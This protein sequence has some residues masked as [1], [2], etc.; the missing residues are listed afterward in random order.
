MLFRSFS[1]NIF[2]SNLANTAVV[3]STITEP[4][5]KLLATPAVSGFI[6]KIDTGIKTI[7]G[8]IKD[9]SVF[10]AD[11]TPIGTVYNAGKETL[12]TIW[13][14]TPDSVK[15]GIRQTGVAGQALGSII[16]GTGKELVSESQSIKEKGIATDNKVL[17]FLGAAGGM[18]VGAPFAVADIGKGV[19]TGNV[20]GTASKLVS[21]TEGMLYE[22]IKNPAVG[23]GYIAGGYV[24]GKAGEAIIAP[25]K[26]LFVAEDI[27][28]GTK[29]AKV[30][31]A[32]GKIETGRGMVE[33]FVVKDLIKD[34]PEIRFM[35]TVSKTTTPIEV[36]KLGGTTTVG[37][38]ASP[39]GSSP[40]SFFKREFTVAEQSGTG[41]TRTF[42]GDSGWFTAPAELGKTVPFSVKAVSEA[43]K[44]DL[45]TKE[46]PTLPG[47]TETQGKVLSS[48]NKEVLGGSFAG[49]TLFK[50]FR[51]HKDLDLISINPLATAT[52]IAKEN[53]NVFKINRGT[54]GKYALV[55]K[56]TGKGVADI[57]TPDLYKKGI[58]GGAKSVSVDGFNVLSP[59][60]FLNI[61]IKTIER[62]GETSRVKA[63]KDIASISE[64][65]LK[66]GELLKPS[67]KAGTPIVY[68]DYF[69]LNSKVSFSD[70]LSGKAKLG[71]G[72]PTLHIE[73]AQK[74]TP[75]P[76]WMK[77]PATAAEK[78]IVTLE[79]KRLAE[80]K[81]TAKIKLGESGEVLTPAQLQPLANKLLGRGSVE[82]WA[83]YRR[84]TEY[85]KQNP[86]TY[87]SP[88]SSSGIKL[89]YE[90]VTSPGVIKRVVPE[91][92]RGK[93]GFG[94]TV[95]KL[96]GNKVEVKLLENIYPKP[97]A[98][99]K[100]GADWLKDYDSKLN[101]ALKETKGVAT[102]EWIK[103][104]ERS[105]NR[106]EG[107]TS[108]TRRDRK[109]V[110]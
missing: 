91:T 9:A 75:F 73:K 28:L 57:A 41:L 84:R 14:A 20:A 80:G 47:I 71:S 3:S 70:L 50:D 102:Q 52:R 6:E 56:S 7:A 92:F 78:A 42:A 72:R 108:S 97:K 25:A 16:I 104:A 103:A 13:G 96:N 53:P 43:G 93:L 8:G 67:M 101:T 77:A 35:D 60:N 81:S 83:Q 31:E 65:T 90:T 55:E 64:G 105:I 54:E 74:V 5:S 63:A 11:V 89:E 109:S 44:L 82:Q 38:Q 85:M 62:A 100:T 68:T 58:G 59:D 24:G 36:S 66:A 79:L 29:G 107:R 87:P 76:E 88:S 17:Q 106:I 15:E 46:K 45:I 10:V 99:V 98:G 48:L 4:Y 23:L 30:A 19:L 12:S 61:K 95:I 22:G 69:G 33:S 40:L 1:D 26:N 37:T 86:A 110:V 18:V 51:K 49:E 27:F 21:S 32:T 94:E 39:G 34:I 2:F